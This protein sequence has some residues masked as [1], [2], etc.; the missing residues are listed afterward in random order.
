MQRVYVASSWRND[1][2][3]AIV[4]PV[5]ESCGGCR[6]RVPSKDLSKGLCYRFP[7]TG[8]PIMDRTGSL[9]SV[10]I[11]P[12]VDDTDW[13]GEY[14]AKANGKPQPEEATS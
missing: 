3:P 6:F 10:V 7:P 13:C 5:K 14:A 2:Q 4:E 8:H 1:R 12:T 11:R 9:S